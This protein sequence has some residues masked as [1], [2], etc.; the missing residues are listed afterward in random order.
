VLEESLMDFP[1]AVVLVTHDRYMLQRLSS[2]ILG[3]D[4][5]GGAHVFSDYTQ[6]E[7]AQVQ[8]REPE[9]G[10]GKT[11]PTRA[12]EQKSRPKN[13]KRL[14]FNEQREWDAMEA[15]ILEAEAAVEKITTELGTPEIA[16]NPQRLQDHCHVLADA[17]ERVD[18]LF[19][20]WQELEQKQA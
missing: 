12:T 15:A 13:T 19:A 9:T 8:E 5:K 3:L 7:N 18:K 2:D 1:G 14:S 4:G 11:E 6:W 17:Q 10:S 20:R 16:D